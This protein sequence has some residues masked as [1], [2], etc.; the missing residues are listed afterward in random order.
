MG[1]II[2]LLACDRAV[3]CGCLL[4]SQML[5]LELVKTPMFSFEDYAAR[6]NFRDRSQ[7]LLACP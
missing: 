6:D 3:E 4:T 2:L 5:L 7:D 1:Y